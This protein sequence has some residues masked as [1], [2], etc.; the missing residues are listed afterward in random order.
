M[1]SKK[2]SIFIISYLQ[3]LRAQITEYYESVYVC[4]PRS[5]YMYTRLQIKVKTHTIGIQIKSR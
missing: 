2:I 1:I 4:S 5:E 3:S